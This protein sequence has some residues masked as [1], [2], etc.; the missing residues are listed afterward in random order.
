[1]PVTRSTYKPPW[2]LFS[3]H[4]ETIVPSLSGKPVPLRVTRERMELS[5]GDFI[6]L[7]RIYTGGDDCVIITHGLEGSSDR[8]YV[9]RTARFYY[10]KGW[11]VIAWNCRSCS[12]ELNRLPRFYHHGDTADLM[13]V[14]KKAVSDGFKR[15]VLFGYSMGG[16]MSLKL[17]GENRFPDQVCGALTFSVP[18]NLRD[19]SD[20]LGL[21]SNRFYER[22]FLNKLLR[23][24]EAKSLAFPEILRGID[25]KAIKNF[26]DF[27][28]HFTVPLHGFED[29]DE[30]FELSTC[31][32]YLGA[33]KRPVLIVNAKNDPMLGEKC[34]PVELAKSSTYV[35]LEIAERGGH[36]GFSLK[37]D[38]YSWMEYRSWEFLNSVIL[39][40]I[41]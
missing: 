2:Y 32:R 22:R 40:Q 17:I 11:S 19:S 9:R 37:G 31:D 13:S 41:R 6:D 20:Q 5:D 23:K 26:D 39:S 21:R 28:G 7:D 12:G 27:H 4:M 14:I 1:M 30:F 25:L 34:Y 18:C 16:S 33:I 8:F 10:E 38:P 24:I 3:G 15:I 36:A 29:V 35:H